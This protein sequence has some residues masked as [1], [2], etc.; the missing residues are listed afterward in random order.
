MEE[1]FFAHLKLTL[2]GSFSG[3][4]LLWSS[5]MTQM[6]KNMPAMQ[7]TQVQSLGRED[8]L[9]KGIATHSSILAWESHGQRS[10]SGYHPWGAK[11]KETTE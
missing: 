5:L 2:F 8:P 1:T 3:F 10:L 6:I 7:E 9:K 4:I 11:S